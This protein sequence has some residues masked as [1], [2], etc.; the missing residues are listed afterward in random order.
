M[1][2]KERFT[3]ARWKKS[4]NILMNGGRNIMLGELIKI[5]MM[6]VVQSLML[7]Q[8]RSKYHACGTEI[9]ILC[10]MNK[11]Q[12]M[13]DKRTSAYNGWS[14]EIKILCLRNIDQNIML[15]ELVHRNRNTISDE[16]RSKYAW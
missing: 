1:L 2:N 7:D 9:K 10:L 8:R 13:H 6:N 16:R 12:H 4:K 11:D 15:D 14:T 5:C 3:Y